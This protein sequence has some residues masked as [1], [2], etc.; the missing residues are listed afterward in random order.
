M[1]FQ[2]VS[3][4]FPQGVITPIPVTTTLRCWLIVGGYERS[5]WRRCQAASDLF[6]TSLVISL[7]SGFYLHDVVRGA[8]ALAGGGDL[9]VARPVAQL[10][11]RAGAE[12]AHAAL[13]P[14]SELREHGV[15]RRVDFLER[16]DALGGDFARR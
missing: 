16:L 6:H 1:F 13:Q 9:D 15:E 7:A 14:A 11:K 2:K 3:T 4:S 10:S 5:D 12:I 8:F